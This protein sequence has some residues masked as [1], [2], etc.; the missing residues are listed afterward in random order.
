MA[1]DKSARYT[2]TPNPNLMLLAGDF[3]AGPSPGL[4]ELLTVVV[5]CLAPH[6]RITETK[7]MHEYKIPKTCSFRPATCI[8][9]TALRLEGAGGARAVIN[10]TPE[11]KTEHVWAICNFARQT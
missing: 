11:P 9:S 10:Y 3:V 8:D 1:C 4:P 2:T 6:G 5:A 7:H